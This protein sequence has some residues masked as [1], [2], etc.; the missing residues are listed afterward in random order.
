MDIKNCTI[1]QAILSILI[2]DRN[3]IEDCLEAGLE[4]SDFS[5]RYHGE[6]YK[7]LNLIYSDGKEFDLVIINNRCKGVPPEYLSELLDFYPSGHNFP[8]FVK[9]VRQNALA[10]NVKRIA[11]LHSKKEFT[12]GNES[13]ESLRKQIYKLES[14]YDKSLNLLGLDIYSLVGKIE[15]G[16]LKKD[17]V[18]TGF[19]SLDR[20]TQIEKGNVV[21]LAS[22]PSMGKTSF[23]LAITENLAIRK[24]KSVG[25]ISLEMNRDELALR[26]LSS[27]S[28]IDTFSLRAGRLGAA[29]VAAVR[30]A[31]DKIF[32]S[33]IFIDDR[34]GFT[35]EQIRSAATRMKR[36][37][38]I[39]LLIIDYLQ[40]LETESKEAS[41]QEEV[42]RI[43]R[44]IKATSRDLEI[45]IIAISQL[46]RKPDARTDKR[47]VLS[48]LRESG[49]IEQDADI[50][51]FLYRESYYSGSGGDEIEIICAKNRHGSTGMVKLQWDR[52][53]NRFTEYV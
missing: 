42:G 34:A 52:A 20:L 21:V 2:C 39:D 14:I 15:S 41:R 19:I 3:K 33:N 29:G 16:E 40:L 43:S 38:G 17:Q 18:E 7:Q 32:S 53:T 26:M 9:L 23:A 25:I 5:E 28:K 12:S 48:D 1:E 45:P 37:N 30:S 6:I 10:K 50:V 44:S 8:E 24:N 13:L 47:P 22:R 51:L 31:R 35:V 46:S 27:L 49:S 4:E 11:Q 36:S